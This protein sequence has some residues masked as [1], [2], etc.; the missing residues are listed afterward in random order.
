MHQTRV[1]DS[2]PVVIVSDTHLGAV[3][4]ATERAFLEFVRYATDEASALIINGDLFDVGPTHADPVDR[5][6]TEVLACLTS[7]V[8]AG[9]AI[10]FV[11]GNRDPVE[12]TG[13]A[14]A[15]AGVRVLPDPTPMTL[16]G[17]RAL[18]AHG[19]GAR[20]GAAGPYRKPY[21]VLR[22][23]ALVWSVRHLVPGPWRESIYHALAA[24]SPTRAR[25]ARHAR[26]ESTGPKRRAPAI[27]AW[28]RAALAVD[29]TLALVVAGHSHMPALVEVA[30]GR[31]YVNT[32]DWVSHFTYATVPADD[33][34]PEVRLWPSRD[35]VR[36]DVLPDA[37]VPK[38]GSV[39][40]TD[41]AR[42]STAIA[43]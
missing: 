29:S 4:D 25:V 19:D 10:H 11:G 20:R 18:V 40:A 3:P 42:A 14:L 33:G 23:P 7:A 13:P 8:R 31:F 6:H 5:V 24:R 27:E 15:R 41:L 26:G 16:A 9:L 21:P 30:P 28:A 32:G 43:Q 17:R 34:P 36:W 1:Y 22:H 38:P 35:P 37:E 2:R 12:W 39:G